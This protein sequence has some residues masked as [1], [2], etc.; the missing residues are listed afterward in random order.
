MESSIFSTYSTRENRV[1]ASILAVL[2]SLSLG[3]I[4]RLLGALMEQSDFQLVHFD[5]QPS[6]GGDGVPDA[7]I[8]SSCRLFIETKIKRNGVREPQLK[9]HL[10]RLE[11]ATEKHR[12]LVVLT[13]DDSRPK[14][15][16]KMKDKRIIW[17]SFALLDQAIN[18]LL[19]DKRE[20]VSEREAFLLRE[21]QVMFSDEKLIGSVS[22]V[23][24]IPAR[25]AWPEYEKFH[26]YVCQPNRS[27][28]P[29]KRIAFYTLGEICPLVPTVLE[30]HESV[31]FER[32]GH[33][34]ALGKL[35]N[36][37]LDQAL[38]DEGLRY[39]VLLLSLPDDPRTLHLESPITN[40]LQSASGRVIAF[41]QNQRY[42]SIEK[43]K[44][45]R[46]TSELVDG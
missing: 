10:R 25:V 8:S 5:N 3:R 12:A 39:K 2:K 22:D 27:F 17:A 15:I 23:L 45:A 42:V 37:L 38:R 9:R 21:L 11:D 29:V 13:P 14:V 4:D 19:D 33:K 16:S 34:G 36:D 32:G 26:A 40:D 1:T 35:V 44:V 24:V 30:T 20:V 46:R 43:L 6:K 7:L 41:T 31:L 18:E 28:Q